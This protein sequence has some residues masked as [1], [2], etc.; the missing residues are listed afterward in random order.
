ME[1]KICIFCSG[2]NLLTSNY[3]HTT[4]GF[5]CLLLLNWGQRLY[6]VIALPFI[7][8]LFWGRCDWVETA[9]RK[10][11]DT[12]SSR[13][14]SGPSTPSET[15]SAT[16]VQ[17]AASI[18]TNLFI[19]DTNT[20]QQILVEQQLH[21]STTSNYLL[22]WN[23]VYTALPFFPAIQAFSFLPLSHSFIS[24]CPCGPWA[25]QWHRHQQF[26][27]DWRWQRWCRNIPHA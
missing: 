13:T 16:T 9:W 12:L 21:P 5:V 10:S 3:F 20:K 15:V 26:W 14:T 2:F 24:G 11:S 25:E 27:W 7:L 1:I 8:S 18:K 22:G 4:I 6:L 17:Q 23:F 19:C